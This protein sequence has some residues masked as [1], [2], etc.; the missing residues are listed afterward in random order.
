MISKAPPH[1]QDTAKAQDDRELT[2]DYMVGPAGAVRAPST[3][4][5]DPNPETAAKKL[6]IFGGARLRRHGLG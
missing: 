4:V 2:D 1:F 6:A 5:V 3:N